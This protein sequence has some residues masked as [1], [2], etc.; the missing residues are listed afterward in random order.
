[1]KNSTNKKSIKGL[2]FKIIGLIIVLSFFASCGKKEDGN[3]TAGVREFSV[4]TIE[5]QNTTLFNEF[6]ASIQGQQNIAIRPKIDGYIEQILIDEGETVRK[7]QLLFII[8]APQYAQDVR[9][10]EANVKI[11]Q[12]NV[13][14]AKMQV[15]KVRPLVAKK[16]ISSYELESAQYTLESR[17]A[18]LLQAKASLTNAQTNLGYTRVTSPVAGVVGTLPYKIGSLINSTTPEP[19]TTVYNVGTIY[20]YFSINEK[21]V[22]EFFKESNISSI[23]DKLKQMPPV[24]LVLSN[25]VEFSNTGKIETA[26]G[27]VNIET[28]SVNIRASFSNPKNVIKSGSSG[29]VKIPQIVKNAVIIPQRCTYEIQGKKFVYVVDKNENVKSAEIQTVT[30]NEGQFYVVSDGLKKGD[31]I[32]LEGI[33]TLKDGDLIKSKLINSDSIYSKLVGTKN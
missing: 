12:A 3:S 28:G 25:G 31:R 30:S 7:G 6:P 17:S 23:E 13:N 5:P 32:V 10:A 8:N 15:E 2:D 26:S 27:L 22:L 16:I 9:T 18:E 4:L 21:Q 1:M 24:A 33:G 29:I 14:A 11:A 20:A 19:L